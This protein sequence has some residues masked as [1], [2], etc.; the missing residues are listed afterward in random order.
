MGYGQD[1]VKIRTLRNKVRYLSILR[2]DRTRNPRITYSRLYSS[3]LLIHQDLPAPPGPAV[4]S[5][6]QFC[7]YPVRT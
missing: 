7:P 4:F 6:Y 1:T 3:V 5:M 2:A